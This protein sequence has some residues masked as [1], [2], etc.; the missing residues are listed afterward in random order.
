MAREA[1]L[2]LRM[3][4]ASSAGEES[5]RTMRSLAVPL[6]GSIAQTYGALWLLCKSPWSSSLTWLHLLGTA[7]SFLLVTA[8]AHAFAV[9]L[10]RRI[11]G[12]RADAPAR[13]LIAAIWPSV[14]W[15]PLLVLLERESS[16]WVVVVLAL[17]AGSATG[18]LRRWSYGCG[19]GSGEP[20][21]AEGPISS[22]FAPQEPRNLVLVLIPAIA[23]AVALEGA[24]AELAF[25]RRFSAG[26][27]LGASTVLPVWRYPRRIRTLRAE[28]D[29][30]SLLRVAARRTM[31][32]FLL[33][34]IAL[35]PYLR[36]AHL[37]R[38]MSALL[39]TR[40]LVS[41]ASL[42]E[43]H[44]VA[45]AHG[46]AY[47]GVILVL[48]PKPKHEVIVPA[49]SRATELRSFGRKSVVIPFDGAYWYFKRPDE[50]PRASAPVVR[51][52]PTRKEIRSTDMRPLSMEAHQRLAKSVAMNCCSA[53]RVTVRNAEREP[54]AIAL[55]VLLR[56][57]GL[58]G[59][60]AVSLG[61]VIIR[62][63]EI[64]ARPGGG[65]APAEEVLSFAFPPFVKGRRFDE[66]AVSIQS[67]GAR[68][69]RGAHVAIDS[70]EL[71]P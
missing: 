43:S 63:S 19:H 44:K 57:G 24:M 31:W 45:G 11:F 38:A 49:P 29:Q 36:S 56:D 30:A 5:S 61:R 46:A 8:A 52:D 33:L 54:G 64:G 60:A 70:F 41:G 40:P 15:M 12:E 1:I 21:R 58:K 20:G 53:I 39:R 14:L 62:S 65:E 18:L 23:T 4:A 22:V 35:T 37:S 66:I 7:V 48:P 55:E 3:G 9:W 28:A 16:V 47:F 27:L 26:M 68:A 42:P 13:F 50:R 25:G 17:I 34:A 59:S 51:G 10:N 69:R 2:Q 67:T 6:G 71:I 32:M